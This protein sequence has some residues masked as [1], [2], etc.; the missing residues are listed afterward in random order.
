[1]IAQGSEQS[2]DLYSLVPRSL[3]IDPLQ[4]E[5]RRQQVQAVRAG[6]AAQGQLGDPRQAALCGPAGDQQAAPRLPLGQL[7][8]QLAQPRPRL[9]AK[10]QGRLLR[11][12]KGLVNPKTR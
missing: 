1:V 5:H 2:L 4:V 10:G 3:G 12:P 11:D 8:V 6:Q 9:G 7:A